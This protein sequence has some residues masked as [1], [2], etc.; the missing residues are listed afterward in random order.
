MK[1]KKS[2]VTQLTLVTPLALLLA[3]HTQASGTKQNA[4]TNKI[5]VAELRLS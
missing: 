5:H 2:L 4:T 1:K 3:S